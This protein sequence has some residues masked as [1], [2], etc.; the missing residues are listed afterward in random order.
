MSQD[1][2]LQEPEYWNSQRGITFPRT[3]NGVKIA[4]YKWLPQDEIKFLVYL[5]H[6]YSDYAFGY[7][8]LV[9]GYT[10]AGGAVYTH[11]HRYHGQGLFPVARNS[12]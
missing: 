9:K 6:G 10:N 12:Q 3:Q 2:I 4:T 11:E 5:V 8:K 1:E 7:S